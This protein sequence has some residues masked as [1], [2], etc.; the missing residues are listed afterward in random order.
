MRTSQ[1]IHIA[2][3]L[4]ERIRKGEYSGGDSL[5]S[6]KE[7]AEIFGT[8][9][10][11]VRQAIAVLEEEGLIKVVHGLGTFVNSGSVKGFDLKLKGFSDDMERYNLRIRTKILKREFD[12]REEK[13][14]RALGIGN[15]G[16]CR[17]TRIRTFD[18]EPIIFQ[19]SCLASLH[20]S[21]VRDLTDD[22]SLYALMNQKSGGVVEGREI[23]KPIAL[24]EAEAEM[25]EEKR[26]TLALLSLRIS[27]DLSQTPVLF[28]EAYLRNDRVLCVLRET[29]N[30][31]SFN[32]NVPVN[33]GLDSLGQLLEPGF[34]EET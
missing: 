10:M 9:V 28:D 20:E 12:V 14:Q 16:F 1:Y 2:D 3:I 8:T 18:G 32:Y 15:E 30:R 6:Q 23:L 17:L 5:G 21:V 33:H 7:L 27:F 22:A 34:W 29:G 25:L 13:V 11:T 24:G 26:G 31:R 4:R 19:R